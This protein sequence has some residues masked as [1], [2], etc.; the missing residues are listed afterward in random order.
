MIPGS[1]YLYLT[2]FLL[3]FTLVPLNCQ[4]RWLIS[5]CSEFCNMVRKIYI[6]TREE[7]QRMNP[8]TLNS[9]VQ[10]SPAVSEER[11]SSKETKRPVP[12]ANS[13][14]SEGCPGV[15]AVYCVFKL[16]LL[17]QLSLILMHVAVPDFHLL[18]LLKDWAII[19]LHIYIWNAVFCIF[20]LCFN[21]KT[22]ISFDHS[23][24]IMTMTIYTCRQILLFNLEHPFL[25]SMI[26]TG[27]N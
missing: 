15:D 24:Y 18:I 26:W 16:F 1:K 12:T 21:V 25:F 19:Y 10:E 6:Y 8:G 23:P 22:T 13:E 5:C 4:G 20:E 14:N 11:I 2:F 9:R 17:S 7:V 27:K 3:C